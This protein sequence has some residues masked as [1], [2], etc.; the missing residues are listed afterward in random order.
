ML[1]GWASIFWCF[2][3]KTYCP[4]CSTPISYSDH[5]SQ[6][7]VVFFDHTPGNHLSY[8]N[9]GVLYTTDHH[10]RRTIYINNRSYCG[11]DAGIDQLEGRNPE[12]YLYTDSYYTRDFHNMNYSCYNIGDIHTYAEIWINNQDQGLILKP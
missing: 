7:E 10:S 4:S 1:A 6:L 8:Y 3:S 2:V 9:Y 5:S 11:S 12:S